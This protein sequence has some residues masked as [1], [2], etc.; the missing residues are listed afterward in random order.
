M[1]T[2]PSPLRR[3]LWMFVAMTL[4]LYVMVAALG[5][6][7]YTQ[8]HQNK[9][10]LCALR[11]DLERRVAVSE[12]FL[13]ENPEGIPGISPAALRTSITNQRLTIQALSGLDC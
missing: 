2:T 1:W 7:V 8:A 4:V 3:A 11:T 9:A 6:F 10:A 5:L 12:T 13:E